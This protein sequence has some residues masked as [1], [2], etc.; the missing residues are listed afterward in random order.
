MSLISL[1]RA[2]EEI[3]EKRKNKQKEKV[4]EEEEEEGEEERKRPERRGHSQVQISL[5]CHS[6]PLRVVAHVQ[7]R[8]PLVDRIRSD[9]LTNTFV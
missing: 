7:R 4:G 2:R 3:E 6:G 1:V 8:R 9:V 5:R